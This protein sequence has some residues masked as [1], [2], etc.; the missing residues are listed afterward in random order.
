MYRVIS[1]VTL[2]DLR[3]AFLNR[4]PTTCGARRHIDQREDIQLVPVWLKE[5]CQDV[6]QAT[7]FRFE[8]RPRVM[9][10]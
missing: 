7:L 10:D 4:N 5:A 3:E 8:S 6:T 2:E 1:W 9:R